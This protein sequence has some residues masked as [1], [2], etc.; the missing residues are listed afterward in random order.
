MSSLLSFDLLCLLAGLGLACL[1]KMARNVVKG[2]EILTLPRSHLRDLI[3]IMLSFLQQE[4]RE[5]HHTIPQSAI[6]CWKDLILGSKIGIFC[7]TAYITRLKIFLSLGLKACNEYVSWAQL[8]SSAVSD[9]QLQASL[10]SCGL[11]RFCAG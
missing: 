8:R 11:H 1:G 9:S 2:T 6:D 10:S 4:N 7:N 5:C 3:C